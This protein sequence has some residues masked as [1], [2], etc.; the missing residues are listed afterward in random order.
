[1]TTP[2]PDW[3]AMLDDLLQGRHLLD[4]DPL[5]AEAQLVVTNTEGTETFRARS[6]ATTASTPIKTTCCGSDP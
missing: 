1:M 3:L 6:P 5:N 2:Q 4:G